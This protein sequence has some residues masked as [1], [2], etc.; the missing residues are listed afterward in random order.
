M[1][2][3]CDQTVTVYR[4]EAGQVH[5]Q[6]LEGCWLQTT[7]E[8]EQDTAGQRQQRKFLLIVPGRQ[9]LPGDRVMAGE[10]P[11][12]EADHWHR[13]SPAL[14]PA[15]V[16]VSWVKPFYWQGILSHTEAGN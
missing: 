2:S 5:R 4:L 16:Q 15:L 14:V 7:E 3:L 11:Q 6:V 8:V 1:Y 9:V 13:F 10:G 12:V